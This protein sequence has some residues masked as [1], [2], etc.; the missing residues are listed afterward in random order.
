MSGEGISFQGPAVQ[1]PGSIYVSSSSIRKNII[2]SNGPIIPQK[3]KITKMIQN[4]RGHHQ[5]G[6]LL[7]VISNFTRSH[8]IIMSMYHT[9]RHTGT[10]AR[11]DSCSLDTCSK[12]YSLYTTLVSHHLFYW[13]LLSQ[14]SSSAPGFF[15]KAVL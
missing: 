11:H 2:T 5:S 14:F 4:L 12:T 3:T 6:D 9:G 10:Q 13:N 8:N 7:W 1:L 15:P